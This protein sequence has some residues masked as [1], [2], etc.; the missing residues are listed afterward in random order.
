MAGPSKSDSAK[1][2]ALPP[3]AKG[4][5]RALAV[6][7]LDKNVAAFLDHQPPTSLPKTT[8]RALPCSPDSTGH[9]LAFQSLAS[10]RLPL[11]WRSMSQRRSLE[12]VLRPLD[13]QVLQRSPRPNHDAPKP[14]LS[15]MLHGGGQ[16]VEGTA[17]PAGTGRQRQRALRRRRSRMRKG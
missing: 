16:G 5:S 12:H 8:K 4:T 17:T 3:K 9:L 6:A 15:R 10:H 14:L 7:R 2:L 13:T 11:P 1:A